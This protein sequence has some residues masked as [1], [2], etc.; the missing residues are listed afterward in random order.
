MVYPVVPVRLRSLLASL[1]AVRGRPHRLDNV[2]YLGYHSFILFLEHK[3][4][5]N[6]SPQCLSSASHAMNIDE[7]FPRASSWARGE[8]R[9]DDSP[10]S[11]VFLR[12]LAVGFM[13]RRPLSMRMGWDLKR[14]LLEACASR[15]RFRPFLVLFPPFGWR[16][17]RR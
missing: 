9:D 13:K 2:P 8:R 4:R 12:Q 15:L 14:L 5:L 11:C 16:T 7:W 1:S 10:C 3:P 6:R 17:I